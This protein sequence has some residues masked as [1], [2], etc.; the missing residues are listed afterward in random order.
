MTITFKNSM[1]GKLEKFEPID[2]DDVRIYVCG[3]TVYDRAHLG[4]ARSA[5]VFDILFRLLRY[6][7]GADH[8]TYVRNF[9]DVDDKINARAAETGKSITEITDETISWYMEDMNALNVL[10]PTHMPRAT[11][12]IG[13]MQKMIGALIAGGHAYASRGHV[14]F[15]VK[16]DPGYGRLSG[17]KHCE[18]TE[19]I[20]QGVGKRDHEDFVLW[21][22]SAADMPAWDSPWGAGRP[23]WHIECSAMSAKLLGSRF[24]IHGGG[25]DLM[26]PHHENEIS[27]SCC[28]SG[29]N[30]MA[31]V[32][33]HN[34]MLT[35]EGGKMSKSAGNFTTVRDVL[36][37]GYN[38]EAM[39]LVFLMS[40]Y[41][42]TLNW[43]FDKLDEA[44]ALLSRWREM[45]RDVEP[46]DVDV[47][48]LNALS[49]NLNTAGLMARLFEIEFLGE[50]PALKAS[51]K[52]LGFLDQVTASSS[53][54]LER[55]A[56][57]LASLREKAIRTGDYSIADQFRGALM[58]AGLEVRISG[59]RVDLAWDNRR[60]PYKLPEIEK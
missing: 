56:L 39:R 28:A 11:Q 57:H 17:R 58:K 30:E 27:Q 26:F 47:K 3:P 14:Y 55:H 32:W 31:S 59:S 51:L 25:G 23:G 10:H 54:D 16:S 20:E 41:G 43:S 22:P 7:Y 19:E 44:R 52:L 36:D 42:K 2:E 8:V 12:Y 38:G 45:T 5:V 13:E 18:N 9:T 1:T 40:N 33:M 37:R 50:A 35:V 29:I 49:Q 46:G 21:K 24:D 53:L 34:G 4:N 60:P 15:S 48:I 6:T